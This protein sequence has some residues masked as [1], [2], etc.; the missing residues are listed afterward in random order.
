[1]FEVSLHWDKGLEGERNRMSMNGQYFF[2]HEVLLEGQHLVVEFFIKP[3]R[4]I[5]PF[6][7]YYGG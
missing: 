4:Q 3:P 7:I 6:S 1:M 2:R 5:H